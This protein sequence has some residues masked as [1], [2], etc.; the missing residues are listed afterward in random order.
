MSPARLLEH[1]GRLID[2]PD[3]VPRLRRFI[4]D[5]AVRGKLVEQNPKD[6]PAGALLKSIRAEKTRL[7]R[8]GEIR[9]EKPSPPIDD[10][11]I[12]FEVPHGWHWTRLRDVTSYLQR[13]KSPKYSAGSGPLVVSQRC[14]QWDG[15]HLEWAKKITA[16][17]LADY[18]PIRFLRDGDLLWNSTGTGTIGRVIRLEEPGE[19]LV[20]DSHIT[21]VRCLGVDERFICIWLRTDFVYGTI[22]DRA[23]GATNQVELTA[24]IALKQVT[25]VPPLAEQHRIVAKVDELMALCDELEAAQTKRE[26]RRDRLV[27]ATLHGLNNGDATPAPA[28]PSTFEEDARFY[29]N[30]L[31]RLTTRPEH[32]YQLRQTI[33]NLA[34]HG[35]LVPQD[36]R[37]EPV[38]VLVERVVIEQR[39]AIAENRLNKRVLTGILGVQPAYEIPEGWRWLRLAELITFGPQNGTSPKPTTN[40]NAPKALT[41]TAT[42]SGFFNPAHYKHVALREDECKNYWLVEGDVL[43][44]RGNTREYVGMATVYD[45]SIRSF[46]FPDLMIRVRFAEELDLRFLHTCLISPLLRSYFSSEASG[47]SST[48]PKINQSVIL[49]APIPLPPRAE[50]HRI[51]AKLDELMALCA[52][53]EAG[54]VR[55]DDLC[56]ASLEASL[57]QALAS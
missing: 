3:A 29:F 6:E 19:R 31:P 57:A 27:A 48:M 10:G 18:E 16:E 32:I 23:A 54:L 49:N 9:K 41:L 52:E 15:L 20:C 21:V 4:L 53:L 26:K 34:V 51:V 45:G 50:Q 28:A 38:G 47:A 25:P 11:E 42:T 1:F 8:S 36:K 24:S 17:S 33:L 55:S 22:E 35:K 44:Q 13:G 14:V 2:T 40:E 5:L 43:F 12:L 30:H 39:R 56:A 37:D 7:A 46:V